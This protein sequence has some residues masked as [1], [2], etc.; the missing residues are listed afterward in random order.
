[1]KMKTMSHLMVVV[2]TTLKR[3]VK[4]NNRYK[5]I[6]NR[7]NLLRKAPPTSLIRMLTATHL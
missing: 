1:M 7:D 4:K 5:E 3:I 2:T 6:R